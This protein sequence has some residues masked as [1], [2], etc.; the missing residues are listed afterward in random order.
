MKNKSISCIIAVTG[1][2]WLIACNNG[3]DKKN[4]P[5][6]AV[7]PTAELVNLRKAIALRPDS[8]GLRYML[9]DEL[10]KN[11]LY[12]E[13]LAESDTL[14]KVDTASAAVWYRRGDILLQ[15]GDTVASIQALQNALKG[16]PLFMEPQLQLA[17][18]YSNQSKPEAVAVADK[19]IQYA[20]DQKY[21]TQARFI[22]GLYYSN[23]NDKTKAL[24]QFNECIK[25]DYTFLDAY[26][27]KGLLL[28]DQKNYKEAMRVFEQTIQVSNGFAEGYYNAG[29]CEEALGNKAEAITY[30]QKAIGLDKS[31]TIAQEALAR[32]SK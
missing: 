27:E 20:Q 31:F 22:K 5:I 26:V 8:L 16:G 3:D 7:G 2:A 9:M 13:A 10:L 21:A 24:E 17:A 18:I 28:Y 23:I 12:N 30:Y 32:V 29:R 1:I 4:P 15:K 11:K 14:L 6:D 25:N 19:I